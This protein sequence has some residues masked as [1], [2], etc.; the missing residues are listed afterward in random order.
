VRVSR[1]EEEVERLQQSERH[2]RTRDTSAR[3]P[4]ASRKSNSSSGG[5]G[6][7]KN[8]FKGLSARATRRLD[9]AM[10]NERSSNCA[11]CGIPITKATSKKCGACLAVWCTFSCSLFAVAH[12]LFSSFRT[13]V[14]SADN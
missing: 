6:G 14:I 4:N 1:A 12:P 2:A 10:F 8:L 11:G 9:K 5:S 13:F 3:L 7:E